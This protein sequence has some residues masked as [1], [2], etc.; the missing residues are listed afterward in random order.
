[1]DLLAW[2]EQWHMLPEHGGTILCAVSGGRDSV[3]LL[4]YL[5]SISERCGFSVAAGHY[6]HHMRPTA[7]RDEDF[8]RD[9]CQKLEIPFYTDGADVC[10]AAQERKLGVEETGRQLRYAFLEQLADTIGASRIA[11]AHHMADQAETVLLH[12]LRGTG[13][14]GLAGIPPVRGRLIRPLLQTPRQEIEAYLEENG[15]GCV[16]DETNEN[17]DFARNRLRLNVLPELEKINPA[18]RR[19]IARTA[20]IV[21]QENRYLNELAA[22]YLPPEGTAVPCSAF[23]DAP[24]AL[25]ARMVRLLL[26]R[27]DVGK[28]DIS[29]AHVEAVLRLVEENHSGMACLPAGASA[30]VRGGELRLCL[31]SPKPAEAV[32]L[33]EGCTVWGGFRITMQRKSAGERQNPHAIY[34]TCDTM[35]SLVQAD[36]CQAGERL[37]LPDSRGGRSVKRLLTE[38]GVAPEQRGETPCIRVDGKLAAVYGVGTDVHFTPDNS[39]DRVEITFEKE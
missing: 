29:A 19:N 11:T 23:Q 37:V 9:L 21:G 2:M 28:K 10:R 13:S 7:Q 22:A 35:D 26:E 3:C 31:L 15:L 39:G 34:L 5:H 36:I 1:M 16:E 30:I 12:L 18:L 20:A 33:C 4:H 27:L 38:R 24:Q 25:R 17:L 8:V 6:N 32:A 14:E